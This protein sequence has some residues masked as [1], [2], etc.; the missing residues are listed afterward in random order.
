MGDKE[1]CFKI[2][3]F[4]WHVTNGEKLRVS[5]DGSIIA[6]YKST[7]MA[8]AM[9]KMRTALIFE[10]EPDSGDVTFIYFKPLNAMHK[11]YVINREGRIE[12]YKRMDEEVEECIAEELLSPWK[13]S[14][15]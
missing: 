15:S 3:L 11:L 14:I 12:S 8:I 6:S 1:S 2:P 9:T 13:E 4:Y 5:P 7:E 10:L